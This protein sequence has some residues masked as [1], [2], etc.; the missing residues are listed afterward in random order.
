MHNPVYVG[1]Q[2]YGRRSG[3]SRQP[4]GPE[5][6]LY[7]PAPALITEAEWEA[8]HTALARRRQGRERR[9]RRADDP[10][11]LRGRLTCGHC[12]GPLACETQRRGVRAYLPA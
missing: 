4:Q 9:A 6:W 2:P 10:F 8:A 7:A 5:Q 12:G 1:R 11:L 3:V